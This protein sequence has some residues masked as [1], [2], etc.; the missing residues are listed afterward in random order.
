MELFKTT[1]VQA[2]GYV[3]ALV[4]WLTLSLLVGVIGGVVG[5]VFHLSIDYVTELRTEIHW[6]VYLLPVGGLAIAFERN[7]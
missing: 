4:K 3:K 5:S 6:L 2:F 7:A 1:F